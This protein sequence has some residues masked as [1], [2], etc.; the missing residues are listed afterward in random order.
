MLV[1]FQSS[2]SFSL[3]FF[4]FLMHTNLSVCLLASIASILQ[5]ISQLSPTF[6]GSLR[7]AMYA[8]MLSC[9]SHVWV[10]A[11]P[12]TVACQIPLFMGILEARMLEWVAMPLLQG[13]FWTQGSNLRHSHLR[14]CRQVLH[15]QSYLG[16]P[17]QPGPYLKYAVNLWHHALLSKLSL[18]LSFSKLTPLDYKHRNQMRLK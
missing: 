8:C 9:F 2:A 13:T 5:E 18:P 14:H 3:P 12:W 6:F 4:F 10:F 1:H 15:P 17:E 16:S 11:T 7:T